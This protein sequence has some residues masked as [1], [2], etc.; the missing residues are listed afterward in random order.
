MEQLRN[1]QTRADTLGLEHFANGVIH[2][3]TKEAITNY[4]KL[5]NDPITREIWMK[6]M[7]KELGRLAQVW[8]NAKGTNTIEFMSHDKIAK[9]PKGKVVTYV[10]IAVDFGHKN[11]TQITYKLQRG[12]SH[13]LTIRINHPNGGHHHHKN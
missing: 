8:G 4:K 10:R 11:R 5:I 9:I 12:G 7:T 2:P 3:V 6:A 1:I 13:Q